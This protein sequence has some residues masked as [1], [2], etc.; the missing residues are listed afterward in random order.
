M[1]LN[2][3]LQAALQELRA[4]IKDS[5]GALVAS[6]DGLVIVHSVSTGDVN[7]LSAMVATGVGLGRRMSEA[8]GAGALG[9]LMIAGSTARVHLY[10]AGPKAVLAVVAPSNANV[11][12]INL[13]ARNA[14]RKFAALFG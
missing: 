14:A 9:E 4:T 13:E 6:A 11:G 2:E 8:F 5:T 12:L 3:Q 1:S 7:Q 10:T